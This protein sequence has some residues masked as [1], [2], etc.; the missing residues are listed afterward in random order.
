MPDL[1]CGIQISFCFLSCNDFLHANYHA[2][3][4][5]V[6]SGNLQDTLLIPFKI[7]HVITEIRRIARFINLTDIFQ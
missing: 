4:K 3:S 1:K 2:T 6:F 5:A 7:D